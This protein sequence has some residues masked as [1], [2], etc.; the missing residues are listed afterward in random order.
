MGW[1]AAHIVG[2]LH[3][4]V[5]IPGVSMTDRVEII[6]LLL[7]SHT[8]NIQITRVICSKTIGPRV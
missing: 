1:G 5:A 2:T 8:I 4:I 3:P 7:A 6:T